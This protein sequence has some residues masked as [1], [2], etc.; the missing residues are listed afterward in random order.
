MRQVRPRQ[1]LGW[2]AVLA[3]VS[4]ATQLSIPAGVAAT[5]QQG[6]A[7]A[8][9]ELFQANCATCHGPAAGGMGSVPA[10]G[11]V[12]E[13]LGRDTVEATVRDGRN[14]MPSFDGRLTAAEITDVVAFLDTL[15]PA[16]DEGQRR[17]PMRDGMWDHMPGTDMMPGGLFASLWVVFSIALL[18]LVVLAVVWL[19]RS[20]G[21]G[22]DRR[23]PADTAGDR[24]ADSARET[25][26][27]RYARGEIGREEYLQ[28]R[29]DLEGPDG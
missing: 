11:G 15:P 28:A 12:V 6:D 27:L 19:A 13:R 2:L 9:E 16:P 14:G 10:L 5:G 8:G 23:G 3:L 20:L 17:R 18:V 4:M 25:L 29:R 26:D 1:L 7:A 24:S 22:R 21:G